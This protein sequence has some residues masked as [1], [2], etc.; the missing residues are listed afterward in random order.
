M[1][2]SHMTLSF[3]VLF[4]FKF[5][6]VTAFATTARHLCRPGQR[7]VLLEFKKVFEIRRSSS[8]LCNINGRI[9]GSYP[10][11]ESWGNNSDCCYWSGVTC[12]AKSKDVIKLDLSCSC[13][14]GRFHSNT[15]LVRLQNLPS[16]K[17]LDLSNNYLYGQI[18]L[19]IGNFSHLTFLDLSSNH[20]AGQIP[21]SIG[22]L[23][24]LTSLSLS[25]NQFSGQIPTSLGNLS[26]LTSLD[27]SSNQFSGQIPSSLG[28]LSHLTYLQ[29]F[30]NQFSDQIPSS[31]GNLSHL[32][33]LHFS[34]NQFS[35]QIPSSIG[36]LSRLTSLDCCENSLVGRIPSSFS[37][38]NQLTNLVVNSN[39]LSGKFP[40]ALLN[41]TKLSHL[42]LS[43]NRFTGTLP[44]NIT[45]SLSNLEFISAYD[46]AFVGPLPS[47]L[48]NLPALTSIYLT[49]NQLEG[50]LKFG[51]TS[52]PS[53]KLRVLSL[54][55]QVPGWL[56]MLPNLGYLDLSN[57]TFIGFE[58]S[59]IRKLSSVLG[60]LF[61]SNNNFSGE[62]PSLVC[63]LHSLRTLDLS[64]NNFSGSIPLCM[65]NLKSTLS[66]LNVRQNRLSGCLPG[67]AFES[68]RSFDVG[69]NQLVGKLPRSLVNFSALEV[70]NVESNMINDTFP[71]W[72]NSLQELKVLVLR[73]NA[74]HGPVHQ[75]AFLKLQII[76]I[77]HNHF[78]G[79]LPSDY[80][81]N[82]RKMSSRESETNEDGSNLNYIGEGYYHDSMVLMNKGIK[83]ELVRILEIYT[84]LDFSGNRLEGEIPKS[85]GL[86]KELHVLNLS[87]NAFTGHIPSSM[88]NLTALESL[89]VSQNNISGEIPQ[90][91]GNLSYLAYMNFSHNQLV[92]LVPGGTQFRRQACSS[93]KDNSGLFGPALDEDCSD[94]HT[95]SSPPYG[96]LE[97]EEE[98][99][100]DVF[101]WIAGA[102]GFVLGLAI[103]CILSG[104]RLLLDETN[105]Q[106]EA[107]Q[108]VRERMK[109]LNKWTV[110]KEAM[111]EYITMFLVCSVFSLVCSF[112]LFLACFVLCNWTMNKLCIQSTNLFLFNGHELIDVLIYFCPSKHFNLRNLHD[113]EV[114]SFTWVQFN[115]LILFQILDAS[116]FNEAPTVDGNADIKALLVFKSQVSGNNRLA[117]GSWNHSTPFCQWKGVACGRKHKRVT[118]LD[119]GGLDL[120][121]IISPAIG[122]LSF[123]KSLNLEDNSFGGT[124]PKEG[125]PSELGSLSS[126]EVLFLSKNN[127]SG[128]LNGT[129]PQEIM[130]LESFV[131]LFV[132]S[133]LLT[134]PLP[135]DVGRLKHVVVL[136][137][138]N[139]RLNGNI[140][141]TIGDCL[142]MEELYL[143]GNAFDGVIP[144]IRNLRAITH[145]NLSNN[146]LSGNVPE[147][148]ANFSTLENLDLSGNNFEGVVPTKG[149]FQHSGKFSVSGNRNLCGGIPELKLKP[150]P[151]NVVSRTRRHSSNK[152]KIFIGVGI[153]IAS[154]LLALLALE[155]GMGGKP[156]REGDLYSFGILL[157]EMFT[158][159]RP[160][161]E[162]F[163][164]DFTLRSYT[165]SALA[166]HVLDI[167]DISIL[168][169][170]VHKKIM[171]TIAEC[172]KMVFNVGIRCCEQ[173][174][175]DRMTMAQA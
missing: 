81:V 48:F 105:K 45:T 153:G 168:S 9:V 117:L 49:N 158:R 125:L 99:E 157:L 55:S 129:I 28:K 94:I 87:N 83:M 173:S 174:P 18:R 116:S 127:L 110:E 113:H 90:E 12:D 159:K 141:E 57:N 170:E 76:D 11:T 145:L 24:Q 72:L 14:H 162:L 98:E 89:D 40:I 44:P 163:V 32:T 27:F 166:D 146:N 137:V 26:H 147:Y 53:S 30:D 63:E 150:C 74:F 20:F 120:G 138:E 78:S 102:I 172:L 31:V 13:L 29:L 93:F 47:S 1:S 104:S 114:V 4:I 152:K 65:G 41:L 154:L 43:N 19:W 130:Q 139:N 134:G 22:V 111:E 103:G 112:T 75:A 95:P 133:N 160:T 124:I 92:G 42:S 2:T 56:W 167:A 69:H 23:S 37:R 51:N 33:S 84:A 54:G 71:F 3:L 73:S 149:V 80:F 165:E 35:G 62:V 148:L 36:K 10:K 17:T 16:L 15:S 155:Y 175:T 115:T 144:D 140:P 156:S 96:T 91:L 88:E 60:H 59:T 118:D 8:K 38:L 135:K 6:D 131:Q 50:S 136:S 164:E 109:Q 70:L 79:I 97:V 161:D 123:L 7:N 25:D 142:Y 132:N 86:L 128:R 64:N 39:K 121:G 66:V 5:Q 143:R 58:T 46:N 82:W 77:S 21:F 52:S 151:R 171:S 119:L 61:G 34:H 108:L 100:E 122:D 68:L 85:I 126:L 107:H 101:C 67:N 169:G 106:A